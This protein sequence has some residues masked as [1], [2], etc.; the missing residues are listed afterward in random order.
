VINDP[1]YG[2]LRKHQARAV[3]V[4]R[5]VIAG[6]RHQK[7]IV[8][9][10]TPGG[11]K[12][13][14]ASLFANELADAGAI[15]QV[16]VIVPNDSLRDQMRANFHDQNRGLSRYLKQVGASSNPV[17]PGLG[18]PFGFVVTYQSISTE[19]EAWR[20]AKRAA[21]YRTLLVFDECHHLC[22]NKAWER[23]AR[24]L[25][26]AAK[27][28]LVMSGTLWRWDE[29]RIPFVNY[30]EKN[31]ALI[32]IRYSRAEALAEKAV[33]PVEFKFFDGEAI[34]EYRKVPHNTRLSL[35]SPKEQARALRTA[36]DSS[37]YVERFLLESTKDWEKYRGQYYPSQAIGVFR[38]Q[39]AARHAH[40]LVRH[41]FAKHLVAC[42]LSD[43]GAAAE[44]AIRSFKTG[45]TSMLLTVKKAYEGL[46]VKAATHLFYM[47]DIRSWPFMDQTIA[48]V[49][50]FNPDAPGM[51]W[52]DQRGYVFLPD[53]RKSRAYV[54]SMMDEQTEYFRERDR[55]TDAGT[56]EKRGRSSF[57]PD[58]AAVTDINVGVDGK[59]FSEEENIGIRRL[60]SEFPSMR[61]SL[62]DKLNMAVRMGLVPL[63][64]GSSD[65]A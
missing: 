42:S 32:D 40:K 46:D 61:A 62:I 5:E 17:L 2:S 12:T 35:A 6:R 7:V 15:E 30:D 44:K 52:E 23:G 55:Q 22:E 37:D 29:E 27:L 58:R 59:R 3:V 11:G 1:K 56:Q 9:G 31:V 49:T 34:Y 28:I 53:D 41:H 13:L 19:K 18:K 21:K 4:A 51:P 43:D 36:L 16:I 65:A 8:A 33:L 63:S 10:V 50:R 26:E 25:A 45:A 54:D 47:S 14:M 48:R 64:P 24:I 60:E 38:K 39:S 20:I 57:H